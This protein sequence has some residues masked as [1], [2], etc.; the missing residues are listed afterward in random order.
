MSRVWSLSGELKGSTSAMMLRR[1]FRAGFVS[2]LPD[3]R[4]C[5]PSNRYFCATRR[6]IA[7][8]TKLGKRSIQALRAEDD[9]RVA[10]DDCGT[11]GLSQMRGSGPV[12]ACET[13]SIDL[14]ST[15]RPA[16]A[17]AVH[18]FSLDTK[19]SDRST[20]SVM[21]VFRSRG[22]FCDNWVLGV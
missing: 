2:L 13:N 4:P 21:L 8:H 15:L 5:T 9:A 20:A 11:Q 14:V 12:A 22:S 17:N 7:T 10:S 6:R 1:S 16:C 3:G 18:P 19:W